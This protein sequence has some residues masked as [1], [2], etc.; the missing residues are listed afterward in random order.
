MDQLDD[1][2]LLVLQDRLVLLELQVKLALQEIL[3]ERV[4]RENRVCLVHL[5][6]R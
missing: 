2:E 4:K 1:Q 5:E 6:S 3:V